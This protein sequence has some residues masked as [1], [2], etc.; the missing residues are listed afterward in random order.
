MNK[1]DI[2]MLGNL[3]AVEVNAAV[4]GQPHMRVYQTR[5][6]RIQALKELGLVKETE[7]RVGR[8]PF[9]VTV[10]GWELTTLGH[11][12]YCMSCDAPDEAGG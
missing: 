7:E 6:K 4:T 10:K 1:R 11:M 2:D 9:A 5:S 8:G 3:F 12:T